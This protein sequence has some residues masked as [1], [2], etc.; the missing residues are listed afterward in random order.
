MKAFIFIT[1]SFLTLNLAYAD[2]S[3]IS[4]NQVYQAIEKLAVYTHQKDAD[5]NVQQVYY[6]I[7]RNSEY[8]GLQKGL[9]EPLQRF[10]MMEN[11]FQKQRDLEAIM[12]SIGGSQESA[13]K[14]KFNPRKNIDIVANSS[15]ECM[16]S[17]IRD[18][19]DGASKGAA[20]GGAVGMG[21][22]PAVSAGA[23]AGGAIVGGAFGAASCSTRPEC[24]KDEKDKKKIVVPMNEVDRPTVPLNIAEIRQKKFDVVVNNGPRGWQGN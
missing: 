16:G 15:N 7:L 9:I 19:L 17:C 3:E 5:F 18:V 11:D 1:I 2:T 8:R 12:T 10:Y 4:E 14:P 13:P 20:I 6:Q 23:A 24:N 22:G 21:G